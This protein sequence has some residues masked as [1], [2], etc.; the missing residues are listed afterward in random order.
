MFKPSGIIFFTLI[1]ALTGCSGDSRSPD[2]TPQLDNI[3]VSPSTL[4]L[5]P[6]TEGAFTALGCFTTP[7]SRGDQFT[8]RDI[9]DSANWEILNQV[10]ATSNGPTVHA[11]RRGNTVMVVTLAGVEGTAV[12]QVNGAVLEELEIAPVISEVPVGLTQQFAATGIFVENGQA[13][14]SQDLT[15]QVDWSSAQAD[16]A[17]VNGNGLAQGKLVGDAQIS[18]KLVNSEG[19]EISATALLEVTDAVLRP[20]GLH[21]KPEQS[22]LPEGAR[23]TF[24][25]YGMFTDG[26]CRNLSYD[27]SQDADTDVGF[28]SSDDSLARVDPY[29]AS[30][31]GVYVYGVPAD[32]DLVQEPPAEGNP[33]AITRPVVANSFC[34]DQETDPL[35]DITITSTFRNPDGGLI[36]DTAKVELSAAE[37][38]SVRVEQENSTNPSAISPGFD[39]QFLAIS[40][41]SNGSEIEI[42]DSPD[43]LWTTSDSTIATVRNQN[44]AGLA[45]GVSPGAVSVTATMTG[46]S[47]SAPLSVLASTLESIVLSPDLFCVGATNLPET[48]EQ[49]S[50]DPEDFPPEGGIDGQV[51]PG[52]QQLVAAGLFS[53]GEPVDISEKLI[54]TAQYGSWSKADQGCAGE[55]GEMDSPASVSNAPGMRGLVTAAAQLTLGTSCIVA[56]HPGTGVIGGATAIVLPVLNDDFSQIELCDAVKLLVD[57]GE[58]VTEA[59]ISNLAIPP[60]S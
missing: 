44:D 35:G 32:P 31:G 38:T 14:S 2:F 3:V 1:L 56:T 26:N 34:S 29:D 24:I 12:L 42:T 53:E 30:T 36:V 48:A 23:K 59:V 25:S 13:Q 46:L 45:E 41:Y 15:R 7:P 40:V 6:G 60:P 9:T 54:W 52:G 43:T 28:F 5:A 11:E 21:L 18:A 10:F 47:G 55:L 57:G 37:L 39:L 51:V 16:I 58:P 33:P 22:S 19:D 27:I 17:P 20:N 4:T 49:A 8:C 50:F